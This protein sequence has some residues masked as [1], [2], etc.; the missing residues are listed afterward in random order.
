MLQVN[1]LHYTK[2]RHVILRG[3]S[4]KTLIPL[5]PGLFRLALIQFVEAP[6]FLP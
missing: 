6:L 4:F 3:L 5:P 1:N 2:S